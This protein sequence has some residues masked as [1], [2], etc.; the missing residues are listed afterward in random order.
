MSD[1]E[2]VLRRLEAAVAG[3]ES[4]AEQRI[5]RAGQHDDAEAHALQGELN[6]VRKERDQLSTQV[7]DQVKRNTDLGAR[8]DKAIAK[9]NKVLEK[10]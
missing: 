7:Q 3:L 8:L 1:R 9:L 4:A 10:A 5:A 6:A 2:K